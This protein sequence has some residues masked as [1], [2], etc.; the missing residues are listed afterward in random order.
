MI[1]SLVKKSGRFKQKMIQKKKRWKFQ[2]V[3]RM[4]LVSLFI[5]YESFS[6]P[7]SFRPKLEAE[8]TSEKG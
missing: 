3:L 7:N 8:L 5:Q 6:Q 1:F 4:N 2:N